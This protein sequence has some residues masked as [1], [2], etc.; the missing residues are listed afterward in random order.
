MSIYYGI[1]RKTQAV[2]MAND[3]C[4][5]LGGGTLA[6]LLLLETAQQETHLGQYRDPTP[7]GAGRGITQFDKIGID[8]IIDRA[9]ESDKEKVREAFGID[10]D[11]LEHDDID[12]QPLTCFILTRLKYKKIPARIPESLE[13]RAEYWKEHYNTVAGKGHASEYVSNA[14]TVTFRDLLSLVQLPLS[15]Y[16]PL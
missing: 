3:V 10:L 15:G 5:A 11:Q 12:F 7:D 9:R 14:N 8:D 4:L 2:E 6:V 16:P 13:G 1:T